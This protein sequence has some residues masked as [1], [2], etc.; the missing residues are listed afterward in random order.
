MRCLIQRFFP[1]WFK[2]PEG[3]Q[4]AEML[5]ERGANCI[6][7]A[8]NLK[9]LAK[10]G[11]PGVAVIVGPDAVDQRQA[12]LA[13]PAQYGHLGLVLGAV[14]GGAVHHIDDSRTFNQRCQQFTL[15]SEAAVALMLQN[16]CSNRLAVV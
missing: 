11:V 9:E 10:R 1:V 5:L 12:G 15:V 6:E 13:G 3:A 4:K 16:K 2:L 7:L 14:W 8:Y